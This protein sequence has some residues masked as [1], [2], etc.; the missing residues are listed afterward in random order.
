MKKSDT[1]FRHKATLLY[2][3]GASIREMVY[4]ITSITGSPVIDFSYWEDL[5]VCERVGTWVMDNDGQTGYW[6]NISYIQRNAGSEDIYIVAEND[7]VKREEE[8]YDYTLD[9]LIYLHDELEKIY[10]FVKKGK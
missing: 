4:K 3:T 2:D 7:E 6:V 8:M 5:G 9:E 10:K 1:L